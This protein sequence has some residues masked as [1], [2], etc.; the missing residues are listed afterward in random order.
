M[1]FSL[2]RLSSVEI[3]FIKIRFESHIPCLKQKSY[4][5]EIGDHI[6]YVIVLDVFRGSNGYD[7]GIKGSP[8]DLRLDIIKSLKFST[9]VAESAPVVPVIEKIENVKA[10]EPPQS[11]PPVR[12]KPESEEAVPAPA[13][14]ERPTVQAPSSSRG[15]CCGGGG[16]NVHDPS[17]AP[18]DLTNSANSNTKAN[19][20][21]AD[22]VTMPPKK[23][24]IDVFSLIQ[25][26]KEMIED[27]NGPGTQSATAMQKVFDKIDSDNSGTIDKSEFKAA[28]KTLKVPI[29]DTEIDA[30]FEEMDVDANGFLDYDEFIAIVSED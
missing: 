6:D 7:S 1:S 28:M 4:R 21:R 26:I 29:G 24:K 19:S 18:K 17:E 13:V 25:E 8:F 22:P 5:F 2:F 14:I 10:E 30:I 23:S 20:A 27:E 16:K 15:G 11:P 3:I 12:P 9:P